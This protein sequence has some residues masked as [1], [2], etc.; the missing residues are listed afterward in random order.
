MAAEEEE[1]QAEED[2]E[3]VAEAPEPAP[4]VEEESPPTDST[5]PMVAPVTGIPGSGS[6]VV[7]PEDVEGPGWAFSGSG[8]SDGSLESRMEEAKRLARLLVTEIKLYNEEQV[9]EGRDQGNIYGVLKYDIY[10]SRVI[11][12]ERVDDDVREQRNFFREELVRIL[13][14]GNEDVLGD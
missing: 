11:F 1:T 6:Q 10:R 5:Q 3:T 14:G 8:A 2:V 12:E 9:A 4:P 7:P 13:A